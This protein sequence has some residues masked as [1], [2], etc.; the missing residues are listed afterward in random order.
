[1]H[2]KA[3]S[4]LGTEEAQRMTDAVPQHG[5]M[6]NIGDES[7]T[8]SSNDSDSDSSSSGEDVNAQ[9]DV[10]QEWMVLPVKVILFCRHMVA[11]GTHPWQDIRPIIEDFNLTHQKNISP[12][13]HL[14]VNECISAWKGSDGERECHIRPKSVA[15]KPEGVGVETK[16]L[17]CGET[18]II[19]KF[20][21]KEGKEANRRKDFSQEYGEGTA[22]TL[23]LT[24]EYS[25]SAIVLFCQLK[26]HSRSLTIFLSF[27]DPLEHYDVMYKC[28][29]DTI[30]HP[31]DSKISW[32]Y[33]VI[34][35]AVSPGGR[36]SSSVYENVSINAASPINAIDPGGFPV[37]YSIPTY[38]VNSDKFCMKDSASGLIYVCHGVILD[39]EV[40][41][42]DPLH[43]SLLLTVTAS[44]GAFTATTTVYVYLTNVNDNPPQMT[45]LP[46]TISL[47]ELTAVGTQVFTVSATD[48]DQTFYPT[49]TIASSNDQLN[50]STALTSTSTLTVM[51]IPVPQPRYSASVSQNSTNVNGCG[52]GAN[53]KSISST[54]FKC[55]Y[56][57]SYF[58]CIY[59]LT[60]FKCIYHLTNF[61]CIYHLTNF[62]NFKCIYHLTYFK[63]IYHLTYFK[64]IYHL[65][66]FKCIYHLTYFKC[67]YHLTYFKCIYHLTNFKCIYHLTNFKCI[68][69]L[70]YFKCIYHLTNFK[71]IYHLTNFKCIYHLTNFSNDYSHLPSIDV[72]TAV[73]ITFSITFIMAFSLG[74]LVTI[75]ISCVSKTRSTLHHPSTPDEL[76]EVVGIDQKTTNVII[77]LECND[78]YGIV[79]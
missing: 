64:C 41:T 51:V 17:A 1:M 23:Q 76:Y 18:G 53:S 24:K 10:V 47:S 73:G 37:T 60:N 78:A 6:D 21:I 38:S 45:N 31:T 58:K 59:H 79:H 29:D 12:G 26:C 44:N 49:Y 5:C 62:M 33:R 54:N 56:H 61:K 2:S 20:D 15:H 75:C 3:S 30:F 25:S 57:L 66:Y 35:S 27:L 22:V 70:T 36:N 72:S 11:N 4:C 19:L 14:P 16:A 48:K 40:L 34:V 9:R 67:I 28:E 39:R 52:R 71:C 32:Q 50:D 42:S 55:I 65:T 13:C 69:H 68:Y 8:D 43:A 77:P 74:V 63:C 7:S 46:T